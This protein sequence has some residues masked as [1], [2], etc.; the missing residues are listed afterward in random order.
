MGALADSFYEY[1]I[2]AWIMS[3]KTDTQAKTMYFDVIK[4]SCNRFL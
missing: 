3:G 4:V 2:K 1:L